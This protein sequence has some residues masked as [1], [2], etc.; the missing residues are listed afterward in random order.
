MHIGSKSLYALHIIR[1]RKMIAEYFQ[2]SLLDR[3]EFGTTNWAYLIS[4]PREG[5]Y[6]I[7]HKEGAMPKITRP[8]WVP[9]V[10]QEEVEFTV[11]ETKYDWRGIWDGKDVG[12]YYV[13]RK[14]E[15]VSNFC[16]IYIKM[17]CK[18]QT[19]YNSFTFSTL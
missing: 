10:F 2:Q 16:I 5:G 13:A 14:P 12:K 9:L 1:L 11:W 7:I 19:K 4:D 15:S 3:I 8:L 18:P 17:S 6:T